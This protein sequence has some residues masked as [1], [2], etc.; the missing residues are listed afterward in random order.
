MVTTATQSAPATPDACASLPYPV[1][2][3][4]LDDDEGSQSW[5]FL[6]RAFYVL[7]TYT[8]RR[9]RQN[10]FHLGFGTGINL[11]VIPWGR[12]NYNTDTSS[13][14]RQKSRA[15]HGVDHGRGVRRKRDPRRD[16]CAKLFLVLVSVS[17]FPPILTNV[18]RFGR[19]TCP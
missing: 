16:P 19:L 14:R 15:Q 3:S 9:S 7:R 6:A 11:L 2:A 10:N 13:T 4:A 8:K 5:Q 1:Q 17:H 12:H 18:L